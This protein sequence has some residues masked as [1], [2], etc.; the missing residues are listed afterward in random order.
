MYEFPMAADIDVFS[1]ASI[2]RCDAGNMI[3]THEHMCD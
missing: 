3:Q 2:R 1:T